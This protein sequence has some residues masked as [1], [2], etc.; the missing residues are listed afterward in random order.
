MGSAQ[1]RILDKVWRGQQAGIIFDW[2]LGRMHVYFPSSRKA[3]AQ[4]FLA[5]TI[6]TNLTPPN[7]LRGP[8]YHL[9]TVMSKF[10]NSGAPLNGGRIWWR[11]NP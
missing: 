5:G 11:A 8:A 7:A 6:A 1:E 2:A 3:I 9:P 10:L 4:G